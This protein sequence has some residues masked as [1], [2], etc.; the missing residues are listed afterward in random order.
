MKLYHLNPNGYGGEWFVMAESRE[1]A[2][3]SILTSV[4]RNCAGRNDY[5]E[6]ELI[7]RFIKTG[8]FKK[9]SLD[10]YDA[11]EVVVSEIC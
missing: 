6:C 4:K 8:A 7:E 5:G 9:Y 1:K 11:G 2:L 10:E 3:E